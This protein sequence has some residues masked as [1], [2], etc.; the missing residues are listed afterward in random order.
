M[1][2][3]LTQA[4]AFQCSG[5]TGKWECPVLSKLSSCVGKHWGQLHVQSVFKVTLTVEHSS[6]PDGEASTQ[7]AGISAPIGKEEGT[8]ENSKGWGFLI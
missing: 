7:A 3:I 2:H 6:L 1:L 4:S 8:H 5:I